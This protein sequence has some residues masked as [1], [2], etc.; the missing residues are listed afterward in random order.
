[1]QTEH[2]FDRSAQHKTWICWAYWVD[3]KS[4][5]FL[6]KHLSDFLWGVLHLQH[7]ADV[8]SIYGIAAWRIR[9]LSWRASR[10]DVFVGNR[11]KEDWIK[12]ISLQST[13]HWDDHANER[14]S[15]WVEPLRCPDIVNQT[16]RNAS[17]L[18]WGWWYA[19]LLGGGCYCARQFPRTHSKVRLSLLE[20]ANILEN[21]AG[22]VWWGQR[23]NDHD[24][25][26][27]EC[28]GS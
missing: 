19:S 26:K 4:V 21:S 6:R 3:Y 25:Q 10:Q 12:S 5:R 7:Q 9:S 22:V 18:R 20:V 27:I 13:G 2:S 28:F 8:H 15:H 23:A 24:L 11:W 14:R 16:L 1:M 17:R